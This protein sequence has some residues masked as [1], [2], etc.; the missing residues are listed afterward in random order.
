MGPAT[1]GAWTSWR[2]EARQ[3]W[4]DGLL[5]RLPAWLALIEARAGL[6]VFEDARF[7]Q[8]FALVLEETVVIGLTQERQEEVD[9]ALSRDWLQLFSPEVH[10]PARRARVATHL[11][12]L[13]PMLFEGHEWVHRDNRARL[14]DELCTRGWRLPSEAEWELQWR[15]ARRL[16]PIEFGQVE[17]CADDWHVGYEGAPLDG[18]PWGL[19]ADLVRQWDSSG[20]S[21]ESVLPAR[22]PVRSASI[23]QV[24]PV[25]DLRF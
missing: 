15:V 24:R 7:G 2:L 5:E 11:A 18:Q 10:L 3:V 17:L 14:S 23:T 21:V 6:P 20:A 1:L 16:V 4:L 19:G 9:A 25:I 13:E 12:G 8:R 22:R